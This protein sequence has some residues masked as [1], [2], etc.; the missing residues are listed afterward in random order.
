M[1]N[2]T[3]FFCLE[4]LEVQLAVEYVCQLTFFVVSRQALDPLVLAVMFDAPP[5]CSPR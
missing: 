5:A 4:L 2:L 1:L 3:L